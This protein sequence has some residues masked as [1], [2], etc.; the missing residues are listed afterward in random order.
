MKHEGILEQL[1]EE[2]PNFE[3]VVVS[4]DKLEDG[5][6]TMSVESKGRKIKC[7]RDPKSKDERALI[8]TSSFLAGRLVEVEKTEDGK[9]IVLYMAF[10]AP[11][12][13]KEETP[14]EALRSFI[15]M[16]LKRNQDRS[17]MV[18]DEHIKGD[19][20]ADRTGSPRITDKENQSS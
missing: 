6:L 8:L 20:N 10:D 16:M 17:S 19:E 1:L 3:E 11:P 5:R 9:Y 7:I 12:P 18:P 2:N 14:V 4:T 13:P 15:G